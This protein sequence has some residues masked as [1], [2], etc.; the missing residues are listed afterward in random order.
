MKIAKRCVSC[1]GPRLERA[2]AVLM[3]FIAARVFGWEPIEIKPEW[4]FRDIPA[5]HACSICHSLLCEDCGMLF[6]D[7][8]FDEEEMGALYAGYRDEAYTALRSR[9]E[10]GYGARNDIYLGGSAYLPAI[11][12]FL[13]PHLPRS[14]RVLDWG[15][16]SGM[17]TPFRGS[18]RLHHIYDISGAPAVDG[19][20]S[21]ALEQVRR[22]EYDLIVNMQV[23]EHVSSPRE[24]LAEIASIMKPHTL[25]YVELPHEE[26]VR[27]IRNPRERLDRKRHWHEHVNFFTEQALDE[28]FQK[29]GLTIRERITH[30]VSAGGKEGHI[31]SIVARLAA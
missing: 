17:N 24:S 7:M 13:K 6:L 15:G 28:L 23:L 16:D 8:R 2:P 5:G 3:P 14:P 10:P 30:P 31:F 19:A 18:A 12:A 11:E 21:V 1:D 27:V 4:G 22:N 25:L 20:A 26:I 29:S 9:F